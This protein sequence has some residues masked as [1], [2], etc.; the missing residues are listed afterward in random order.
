MATQ[1]ATPGRTID[2]LFYAVMALAA[3]AIVFVGF[4][5]TYYLKAYFGAAPLTP[6]VHLHGLLFTSWIVLLMA[7]VL[8]VAAGRTD[9]HR[10]L[11]IAGGV[12]AVLMV[13]IGVATAIGFARRALATPGVMAP[14]DPPP[15][16]FLAIP[17][18]DLAVFSTLVGAAL[19]LRRKTAAHKRLMLVATIGLLPAAFGRL[20]TT[21]VGYF[22]LTDLVLAACVLYDVAAHRRIHPA[23]LWSGVL[24]VASQPA[25]L[26]VGGTETWLSVARWLTA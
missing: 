18:G 8:L 24:L 22:G 19:W 6:L 2:R 4:A 9:L 1:T 15:L 16:V 7:Q 20:V 13:D 10:R 26:Y 12:L 14:G 25:R 3:A 21:P 17:F 5:R 23:Y 11:G